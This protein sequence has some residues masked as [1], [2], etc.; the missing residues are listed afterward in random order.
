MTT[1]NQP[2]SIYGGPYRTSRNQ[3]PSTLAHTM[4]IPS[5]YE[6]DALSHGLNPMTDVSLRNYK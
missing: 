5:N 4:A 1:N 3:R 2:K 6:I